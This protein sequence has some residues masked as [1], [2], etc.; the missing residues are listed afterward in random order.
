M[1]PTDLNFLKVFLTERDFEEYSYRNMQDMDN[2]MAG[3]YSC[4]LKEN[5]TR[6]FLKWL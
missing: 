4:K 3:F 6:S 5:A 1:K 2:I